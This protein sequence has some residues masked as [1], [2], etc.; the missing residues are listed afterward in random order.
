MNIGMIAVA[1]LIP[2]VLG[3]VWYNPMVFGKAWMKV[4]G[5][6]ET[7]RPTGGKMAGIFLLTFVLGF[8]IAFMMQFLVIHQRHV[9]SI[10]MDTPGFME[11]GT[12][13][14]SKTSEIGMLYANF[15][16]RFGNNYRTFKHGA[17]HGTMTGVLL[18]TPV[19]AIN[20][21]FERKGFKYIAINGG[22]WIVSLALMGGVV[23]AFA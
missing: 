9:M 17:L 8:F 21:I 12:H 15:M 1:A 2:L 11:A 16:E 20:A 19:I 7:D 5:T 6:S 4:A 10:L 13:Q 22:Y 14:P 3:F 18:V 23:C